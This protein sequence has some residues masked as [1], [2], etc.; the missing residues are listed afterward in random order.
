MTT[1][2]KAKILIV[3]DDLLSIQMTG[4]VL[5]AH[6]YE[7]KEAH[8]G[9]QAVELAKEFLPDLIFLDIVMPRMDGYGVCKR[10]REYPPTTG[11]PIVIVSSRIDTESRSRALEAGATDFLSKPIDPV[12]LMARTRNLLELKRFDDYRK[13]HNNAIY[14]NF[15]QRTAALRRTLLEITCAHD[16]LKKSKQTIEDSLMDTVHRLTVVAEYRDNETPLHI[17]RVGFLCARLAA[18]LGWSKEETEKIFYAAPMHDIGKVAV[19]T[20]IILKPV[21]LTDAEYSIMKTHTLVGADI[22]KESV[23][24]ILKMAEKI[25]LTHHEQWNGTGYP[26]GLKRGEIP[27]EGSIMQLVDQYD[28]LR[29]L[30]PHKTHLSHERV[31]EIITQGDGR[32]EPSH[33]NPVILEAFKTNHAEFERIFDEHSKTDDD[34]RD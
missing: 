22:L 15:T 24:E 17:K 23:S 6:G 5:L 34:S 19:P 14:A 32:T 28:A 21:A 30:R 2:A 29:S 7:Y 18:T 11:I 4:D 3:D 12:E 27:V 25:A 1:P 9:V 33:F 31:V 26:A 13:E 16:T 10:L 8:D 20:D